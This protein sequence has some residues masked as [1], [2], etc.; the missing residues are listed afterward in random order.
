MAIVRAAAVIGDN[1]NKTYFTLISGNKRED[2]YYF[3]LF[4]TSDAAVDPQKR[5]PGEMSQ[6]QITTFKETGYLAVK[7]YRESAWTL[8]SISG[9]WKHSEKPAWLEL[10]FKNGIGAITVARHGW[11]PDAEGLVVL[12]DIT[13]S[14]TDTDHPTWR[15]K[16][17][18]AKQNGFIPAIL[19]LSTPDT[20]DISFEDDSHPEDLHLLRSSRED[21]PQSEG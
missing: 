7:N 3:K 21:M 16:M 12:K 17:F 9:I 20:L 18:D 5:F 1:L 13:K 8:P 4:F 11:N 10:K 2:G 15:G 6:E 19:T 14:K